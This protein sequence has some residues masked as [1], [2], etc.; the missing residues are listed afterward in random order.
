MLIKKE[1]HAEKKLQ[2]R[3]RMNQK[4]YD[5]ITSYC[6]WAGIK[7]RDYFIEQ[8]CRHIFSHD[9]DWISARE[10]QEK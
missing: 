9:K 7:L 3:V 5:E 6:D 2:F 8:A 4:V 1:P 10:H